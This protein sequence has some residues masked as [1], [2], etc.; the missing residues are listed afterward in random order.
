VCRACL[1]LPSTK[2]PTTNQR[3]S[4]IPGKRQWGNEPESAAYGAADRPSTCHA[5]S[6]DRSAEAGGSENRRDQAGRSSS[7]RTAERKKEV[8]SARPRSRGSHAWQLGR[9]GRGRMP[10]SC[11]RP[12]KLV[13]RAMKLLLRRGV[14]LL[15][16][17]WICFLYFEM[18]FSIL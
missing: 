16:L 4:P 17:K 13:E 2:A 9:I 8:R 6:L 1:L 12:V 15:A 11:L 18:H 14:M 3:L 5:P 10:H 7:G